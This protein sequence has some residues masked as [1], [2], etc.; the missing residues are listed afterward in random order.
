MTLGQKVTDFVFKNPTESMVGLPPS[1]EDLTKEQ[2]LEKIH[3]AW[4]HPLQPN[5]H[6]HP[7]HQEAHQAQQPHKTLG[8]KIMKFLFEAPTEETL[9]LPPGSRQKLSKEEALGKIHDAWEHPIHPDHHIHDPNKAPPAA[10]APEGNHRTVGETIQHYVCDA[11]TEADLGLPHG[12][13]EHASKE[14]AMEA[15]H[16]AL[17]HPL[18]SKHEHC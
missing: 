18:A 8:E 11:P 4:D 17:E 14:E 1:K 15:I 6:E 5:Y 12:S 16:D 13:K 9:G 3:D 7:H 10:A 2:T